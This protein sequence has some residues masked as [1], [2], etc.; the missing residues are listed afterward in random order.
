M[1]EYCGKNS[2]KL[3]ISQNFNFRSFL[4]SACTCIKCTNIYFKID[5]IL[6]FQSELQHKLEAAVKSK[7]HYKEQWSKTLKEAATLRQR[8]QS[9]MKDQLRK[10]QLEL[11]TMRE[12]YLQAEE[13]QILQ[14]QLSDIKHETQR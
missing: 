5:C 2:Q 3:N 4:H 7:Q 6:L 1:H 8:E 10:Q 11:E 12:K 14:K 13:Q 9:F